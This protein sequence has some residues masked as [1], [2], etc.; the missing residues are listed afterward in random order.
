ME[1]SDERYLKGL[2]AQGEHERLDFKFEIS[3]A[4]KIAKTLSA[5][6]NTEGGRILVGVKDNGRISGIRSD[7]EFY[8]VESAASLFC[9]PEVNFDT[10][11]RQVEGK[12]VLEVYIPPA[13]TKPVYAKDENGRWL[14]YTRVEDENVL[15]NVVQLQLWKEEHRKSGKLLEFTR[16]EQILLETLRRFP[17]R[18]LSDLQGD[19]GFPRNELVRLMTKLVGF[20]VVQLEYNRSEALF[21]LN[22]EP[23]MEAGMETGMDPG[24]GP[25]AGPGSQG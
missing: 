1:G 11:P 23:G 19:T 21:R 3:D 7:E 4:R 17:G 16:K 24:A 6:S 18:S 13:R 8:M 14:A 12:N 22:E 2:I 9:K 10:H 20:D 25:G 15:T 5:F